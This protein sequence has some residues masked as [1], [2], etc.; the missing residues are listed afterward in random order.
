MQYN[1]TTSLYY[2]ERTESRMSSSIGRRGILLAVV[3]LMFGLPLPLRAG[4]EKSAAKQHGP[5]PWVASLETA[6][7]T[8]AK[9]KKPLLVDFYAD[10]CGPCVEMLKTTYKDKTV[11]A[12]AKKF[13]PVLINVDEQMKLAQQLGVESLPTVLFL[14]ARGKVVL[15]SEGY[16][17]P[18]RFL[19]LMEE[20]EKKA[21]TAKG[22]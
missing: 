19:K 3:L 10:W 12:R 7:K 1:T 13:V 9:Q 11:V 18:E 6:K 4:E 8:A 15:R 22:A 5:I 14:D 21:R 17:G 20:A 2:L 16:A